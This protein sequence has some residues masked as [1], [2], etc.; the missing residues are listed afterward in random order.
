MKVANYFIYCYVEIMLTT[1]TPAHIQHPQKS[2]D[3]VRKN[4][5]KGI[6][7][8]NEGGVNQI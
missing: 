3:D 2:T 5:V 4:G 8:S 7:K 6:C 1:L